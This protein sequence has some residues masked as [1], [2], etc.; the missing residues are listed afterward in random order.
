MLILSIFLLGNV[1]YLA[2]C[3]Q[4]PKIFEKLFNPF[5]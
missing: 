2:N 3:F 4:T 5:T 1:Q